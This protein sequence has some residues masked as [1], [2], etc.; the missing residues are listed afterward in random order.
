[1]PSPVAVRAAAKDTSFR[2]ADGNRIQQ[3]QLDVEASP[4]KVWWALTTTH[5]SNWHPLTWISLE[6]DY[7]LYGLR[8]WGYHLTSLVLHAAN[9]LLPATSAPMGPSA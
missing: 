6:F 5:A 3:L 9:T 8:P 7:Q 1:M 2:G 4:A